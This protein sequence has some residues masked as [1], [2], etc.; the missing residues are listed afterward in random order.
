MHFMKILVLGLYCLQLRIMSVTCS[1]VKFGTNCIDCSATHCTGCLEG[2]YGSDCAS[3]CIGDCQFDCDMQTGLCRTCTDGYYGSNCS[4]RCSDKCFVKFCERYTGACTG[5]IA[6]HC[7]PSTGCK[8]K[9]SGNCSNCDFETCKCRTCNPGDDC[10]GTSSTLPS[11][12]TTPSPTHGQ[13]LI[14]ND[15]SAVHWIGTTVNSVYVVLWFIFYRFEQILWKKIQ[16]LR[17]KKTGGKQGKRTDPAGQP[18]ADDSIVKRFQEIPNDEDDTAASVALANKD[19]N[20]NRYSYPYDRN[21]VGLFNGEYINASFINL[22]SN[23]VDSRSYITTQQPMKNTKDSFWRMIWEQHVG[24]IV[25]L[26]TTKTN[27]VDRN[28]RQ[29]NCQVDFG[30]IRVQT[31]G[32]LTKKTS[33]TVRKLKIRNTTEHG[34]ERDVNLYLFH[35]WYQ[36]SSLCD[37]LKEIRNVSSFKSNESPVTIFSSEGEGPAAI[38]VALDYL[39]ERMNHP[40]LDMYGCVHDLASQRRCMFPDTTTLKRLLECYMFLQKEKDVSTLTSR[41]TGR[42]CWIGFLVTGA[43]LVYILLN[44]TIAINL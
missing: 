4:L 9:C 30:Q 21:R 28:L 24:T 16:Q 8:E 5:C 17:Y 37:F 3:K 33:Y 42:K 19:K 41:S 7:S 22:G 29:V 34:I 13:S 2:F 14:K 31:N 26:S 1:C 39:M 40:P 15:C 36:K 38:F 44:W 6:G 18:L 23:L 10:Y 12:G 11:T 27:G 25:V 43:I 32:T 35:N 20:N